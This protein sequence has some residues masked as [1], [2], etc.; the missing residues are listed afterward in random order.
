M[1]FFYFL[2]LFAKTSNDYCWTYAFERDYC[3]QMS[4]KKGE[5][6]IERQSLMAL[7]NRI[8]PLY[9][10]I[11]SPKVCSL[12]MSSSLIS[13]AEQYFQLSLPSISRPISQDSPTGF[14]PQYRVFPLHNE[15]YFSN[16]W[17][18]INSSALQNMKTFTSHT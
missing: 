13:P 15:V 17:K 18:L 2:V 14:H 16:K 4:K 9:Y 10:S 1:F 12:M 11:K 8:I 6:K 3:L 7:R 5:Q